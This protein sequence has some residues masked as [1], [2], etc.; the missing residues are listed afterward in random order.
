SLKDICVDERGTFYVTDSGDPMG[1]GGAV[2]RV[3]PRGRVEPVADGRR[4]SALKAPSGVV[5][6]GGGE[7][8]NT[9]HLLVLDSATGG[10]TWLWLRDGS[11]RKVADGFGAGDGA[12]WDHYG[13]LY[14][15]DS[16]GGRVF[17]ISRPGQ[18]PVL[19]ASGFQAPAGLG[20]DPTGKFI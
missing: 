20:L 6:A 16:K 2:Y 13:R 12:S 8:T 15:S 1:V 18:A 19:L 14:L 5:M 3:A 11:L 4:L 10:L 17:V 7:Q 9:M